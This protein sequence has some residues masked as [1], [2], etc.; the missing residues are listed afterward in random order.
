MKNFSKRE[1]YAAG[2]P[3][4][5]SVTRKHGKKVIFGGGGGGGGTSKTTQEIPAELKPLAAAYASKAM[6]LGNQGYTPY[7]GQRFA[8]MNNVE[9]SAVNMIAN[10]AMNGSPE[11]SA[12]SHNIADTLN[13]SYL[14]QGNPYLQSQINQGAQSLT[15]NYYDAVKNT[16]AS[17]AQNGSY[18]G[19][20]WQQMQDNNSR[21]LASTLGNLEST[22]RYQN[23]GDERSRQMQ[24]LSLAPTYANQPYQD[25]QQLMNAGQFLQ[26]QKQQGLDYGYQQY[27]D[28]Q[29]LPYKQLA[30][31]SG[32]FGSNL[33]S[34]STTTQTGGGK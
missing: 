6:N 30:A 20:A 33:G 17:A 23:Y 14:S 8:D 9:G 21:N 2:E 24:A 26:D 34:T 25:A 5:D 3:L 1:L 16:D 4:G 13:G 12:G 28:Q 19:S 31:M 15:R 32:V 18:G 11:L 27:Q 10:R 22:V 7:T 29:N